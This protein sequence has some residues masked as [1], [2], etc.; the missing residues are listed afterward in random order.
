MLPDMHRRAEILR[1]LALFETPTEPLLRELHTF[2][3]DWNHAPLL[4][5]TKVDVLRIIDRFL[6]GRISA[7]QLEAWAENLEEREDVAFDERHAE[8]LNGIFFRIA[9]PMINEPLTREVVQ[10][11]REELVQSD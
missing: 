8:L 2:G 11:M 9:T 4:V 10:R 5:L 3:W 1:E 6:A 7:A